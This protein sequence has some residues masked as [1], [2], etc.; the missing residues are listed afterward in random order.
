MN[1][2]LEELRQPFTCTLYK[3]C[4]EEFHKIHKKTSLLKFLFNKV[5]G[6]QSAVILTKKLGDRC[7]P[8]NFANSSKQLIT[9]HLWATASLSD[10]EQIPLLL[11]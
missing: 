9:E 5:A 4:S 6:M 8:I 7:F 10:A 3:N 1:I 2:T 11:L